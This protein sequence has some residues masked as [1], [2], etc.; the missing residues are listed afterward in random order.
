[1]SKNPFDDPNFGN[2]LSPQGAGQQ[3]AK[4][5]EPKNP[6]DDPNY[7]KD[8]GIFRSV[9][10]TGISAAQG[11]VRGA[12]MLSSAVDASSG[13][14][15]KLRDADE[16]IGG[17]KSGGRRAEQDARSARIQRA[18][19][20]GS[21]WE[22]VKAYAGAFAEAPIDTTIESLGTMAPAIAANVVTRGRA[23]PVTGG[24]ISG[25]QGAGATKG[26]I[27]ESV[28]NEYLQA[29]ATPEE[30]EARAAEAQAYSGENVDQIGV[31][32]GLGV[33]AGST[34]VERAAGRLAH[35]L[36]GG[37]GG[38]NPPGLIGHTARGV[39]KELPAEA[40][41]G[42]HERLAGNIALQREG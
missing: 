41:Q 34:G 18:E 32:A 20:S 38:Q 37:A 29:G 17:F 25:A 13:V 3:P 1:M 9:A 31:G 42:G 14:S 24:A 16:Y 7:G 28:K 39:A 6:F 2:D 22:E 35:R 26:S 15:K 4:K 19:E 8:P 27:Y 23:G 30:A 5:K 12:E 40:A 10:D 11:L 21:T 33:L 36:P